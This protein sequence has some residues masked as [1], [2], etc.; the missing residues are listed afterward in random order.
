[1]ILYALSMH[2]L[3]PIRQKIN[4]IHLVLAD[5]HRLIQFMDYG[6]AEWKMALATEQQLMDRLNTLEHDPRR[7]KP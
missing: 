2:D 5:L 6:S 4:E 3:G 7:V 1:M